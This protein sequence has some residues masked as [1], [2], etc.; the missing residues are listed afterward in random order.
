MI[1][2]I[3]AHPK[4]KNIREVHDG[5]YPVRNSRDLIGEQR[6]WVVQEVHCT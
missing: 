3:L 5:E 6:E 1:D 4:A 2:T